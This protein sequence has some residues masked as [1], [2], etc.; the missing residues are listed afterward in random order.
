MPYIYRRTMSYAPTLA[1]A[2]ESF[3]S[4]HDMAPA[5]FGRLAV[6]DPHFVSQV[7]RGRRLWPETEAKVRKFMIEYVPS[8]AEA[9]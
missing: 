5:T 9:A 7:R 4:D 6:K 2:I 8:Q 3:L 1:D